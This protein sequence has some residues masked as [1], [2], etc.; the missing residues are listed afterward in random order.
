MSDEHKGNPGSG[1]ESS[2]LPTA[3]FDPKRTFSR[4][5]TAC[6]IDDV[7]YAETNAALLENVIE[8]NATARDFLLFF[9]PLR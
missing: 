1:R 6:E 3:G 5:H 4:N 9:G 2:V 8:T 7:G